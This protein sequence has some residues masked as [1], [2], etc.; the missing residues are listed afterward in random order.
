[1]IIDKKKTLKPDHIDISVRQSMP[2]FIFILL[3]FQYFVY[4]QNIYNLH[5][6][7]I[8][9]MTFYHT[10]FKPKGEKIKKKKKQF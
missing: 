4:F 7:S 10:F 1:M 5:Q 9:L 6:T 8:L 2:L 3:C